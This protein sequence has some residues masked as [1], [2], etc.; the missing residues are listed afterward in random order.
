MMMKREQYIEQ[1]N[2]E[3]FILNCQDEEGG[4][5]DRPGN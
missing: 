3:Q 4:I 1:N 2:L 5:S